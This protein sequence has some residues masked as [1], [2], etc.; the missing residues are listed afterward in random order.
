MPVASPSPESAFDRRKHPDALVFSTWIAA[1]GWPHRVY[2]W[3]TPAGVAPRG[4][5]LFQSGRVDYIEK[6]LEACDHWHRAGWAVE[7]FDWRGQGG[8][9]RLHPDNPADDRASFDPLVDDLAAYVTDWRAR[10]PGPHVLVGHS[11]GG[12]VAL[13]MLIE[14][15]MALGAMVLVA[16]MLGLNTGA[17][18]APIAWIAVRAAMLAGFG[19]RAAWRD[20]PADPRRQ[21]RL[22]SDRARYEDAQWWKRQVPTLGG[23]APSWRWLATALA[24]NARLARYRLE[25]VRTPVLLLVA[26]RDKLVDGEAIRHTAARLPDAEM[27]IFPQAAH[28]LL[29]EADAY[30][31][32]ALAAID[33]FLARRAPPR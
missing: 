13:R 23:G 6:Y 32:P 1:D 5:L 30:R 33:D 20:D 3:A 10:T 9:G 24:A 4:S 31:L 27:R 17:L 12:H 21:A 22:T 8:S 26:G 16:P 11:M 29:R 7:G 25:R 15:G 19:A 2:R 14:R 28:E 18:P